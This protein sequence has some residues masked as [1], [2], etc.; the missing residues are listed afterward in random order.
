MF[1]RRMKY[2]PWVVNAARLSIEYIVLC[3]YIWKNIYKTI[4]KERL[5][6]HRKDEDNRD[7]YQTLRSH[8]LFG[9]CSR[10]GADNCLMFEEFTSI[11]NQNHCHKLFNWKDLE[12]RRFTE[13]R[14]AKP[15]TDQMT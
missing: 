11:G 5:E 4:C 1:Y 15:Q 8:L 6:Y 14:L 7:T 12:Q 9:C 10:T 2:I 13:A 3:V